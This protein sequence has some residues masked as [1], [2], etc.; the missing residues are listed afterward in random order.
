MQQRLLK[1]FP[2]HLFEPAE[3]PEH[4]GQSL[5][6]CLVHLGPTAGPKPCPP[7][8][9]GLE[10]QH[11]KAVA[12]ERQVLGAAPAHEGQAG[13]R[14]LLQGAGR[15]AVGKLGQRPAQQDRQCRAVSKQDQ[16]YDRARLVC[17]SC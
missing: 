4:V 13:V 3:R 16:K 2:T 11:R 15:G 1:I 12:C 9:R 14:E 8:L 17:E 10:P 7:G 5:A 6:A